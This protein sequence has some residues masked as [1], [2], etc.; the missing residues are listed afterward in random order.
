LKA[1]R[2]AEW[3]EASRLTRAVLAGYND[4][5]RFALV[6]LDAKTGEAQTF[7]APERAA[8]EVARYDILAGLDP[9]GL[10]ERLEWSC[11]GLTIDLTPPFKSRPVGPGRRKSVKTPEAIEMSTGVKPNEQGLLRDWLDAGQQSKAHVALLQDA[12]NLLRL[13]RYGILHRGVRRDHDTVEV[14]W[15]A[16]KDF[17]LWRLLD[18]SCEDGRPLRLTMRDGR[19][20]LFQQTDP[21]PKYLYTGE[22]VVLGQWKGSTR[23][24]SLTLIDVMD[25]EY[26]YDISEERVQKIYFW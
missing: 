13:W 15:N 3:R 22:Q 25:A 18:W 7:S 20:A 6:V 17:T 26:P 4:G 21:E 10:F 5:E 9:R 16:G 12:Q 11:H 23:T 19:V 1:E 14:S 24:E 8:R 2:L